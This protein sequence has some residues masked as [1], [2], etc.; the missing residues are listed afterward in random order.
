M[1]AHLKQIDLPEAWLEEAPASAGAPLQPGDHPLGAIYGAPFGQIDAGDLHALVKGSGASA[2]RVTPWRLFLLEEA[3]AAD[4][5]AVI[6]R[7]GDPLLTVDACPGL[8]RC[9]AA[10]VET[11]DLARA[12]AGQVD[13]SLH[14]SGCSKGCARPGRADVTLVGRGG[15]FDL[16][17]AGL[18]WDAPSEQ[19]LEPAVLRTKG[20]PR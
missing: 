10:T 3:A 4:H 15:T 8:P 18:P 6:C 2:L 5:P 17:Q 13:G 11:R 12:L 14:V 19:G 20:L 16:V 7:P 9:A 1:A